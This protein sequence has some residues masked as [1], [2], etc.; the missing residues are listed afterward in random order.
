MSAA[1]TLEREH[2]LDRIAAALDAAAAGTGRAVVIEGPPGIGKTRLVEDARALGKLRG[3]GRLGAAGD[4]LER[5]IP[6][7]VLRQIV[8]RSLWRQRPEHRARLLTEG[9]AATALAALDAAQ[10]WPGSEAAIGRTLHALWWIVADLAAQRPLLV[11]VDDAHVADAP[12][13]RFLAYLS[14]RIADLPVALIVAARPP[15]DPASSRA[16]LAGVHSDERLAPAALSPEAVAELCELRGEGDAP[17]AAVVAA[18]HRATAGNPLLTGLLIDELAQRGLRLGDPRTALTVAGLGPPTIS[19]AV[20]ARLP[21]AAV[22]LAGTAAV[23]GTRSER[24][25]A[26]AVAGLRDAHLATAI[27]ALVGGHVLEADRGQLV[28]AQPVVREAVLAQLGPGERAALHAQAALALHEAGAPVG[29]VAAHV[30]YAPKGTLPGAAALLSE[31]AARLLADGD[32]ATAAV[33]LDRAFEHDP[34]DA[35][36]E[37]QLGLALLRAGRSARAREHLRAAAAAAG[38]PLARAELLAGA[39]SATA[40]VDGAPAAIAELRAILDAWPGDAKDAAGLVLEASLAT[41]CSFLPEESASAA[42]RLAPFAALQGTTWQ[43]RTLLALLAQRRRY[44]VH[45][46]AEVAALAG[47][48]LAGGAYL[49]DVADGPGGMVG[50]VVAVLAMIAADATEPAE[51]ELALARARIRANGSPLEF[52]MASNVAACL[53]WR[54]GDMARVEAE[55]E[56]SLAAVA[57]EDPSA[58]VAAVRATAAFFAVDAALERDDTAGARAVLDAFDA[59]SAGMP[60]MIPVRWVGVSRAALALACDD[61]AGALAVATALGAELRADHLDTPTVSWRRPAALAAL[62]LGDE[63][64]ARTLAA[65]QL[66]LARRW[67]AAS[68]A[69]AALRLAARV[70]GEGRVDLLEEAIAVLERSPARLELGRALVDLGEALRVARRRSEAHEPLRR[71]AELALAC[72]S[73][74]LRRRAL[75]GLA[76]LGDRPRKLMFSGPESLTASERRVAQLAIEG[77]TNRDIAQEL[78]VTP[79]TVENHLGRVYIKL[80][81][82]GRRELALNMG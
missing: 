30:A 65:E 18:V 11:T 58:P 62:R 44:D 53:A 43:E 2:E 49:A 61:P 20:L 52:G 13:L 19:R 75:E 25:L 67:G 51:A 39:A 40:Q 16:E 57:A 60:R 47:R 5:A 82:K 38:E 1:Q 50:W 41:F 63:A 32:A 10:D 7:S 9:A 74:V 24:S 71:G 79:K 14:R 54:A 55:C 17:D 6:W 28:F 56:A 45:P 21:A 35:A 22:A 66:D 64:Q 78:F 81:I 42:R 33:F 73:E 36:I 37:A 23:L 70:D 3:F 69:G 48:A 15:N 26:A 4:E 68:D 77:R 80:G 76:A 27:D 72:H 8:E 34:A 31:A 29:R 46:A 59:A 12:S